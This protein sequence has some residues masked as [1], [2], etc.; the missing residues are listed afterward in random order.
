MATKA[1]A[2]EPEPPAEETTEEQ[3][4]DEN[5]LVEQRQQD[6]GPEPVVRDPDSWDEPSWEKGMFPGDPN[7]Y[8][9]PENTPHGI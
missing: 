8:P 5:P 7:V 4:E 1:S 9:D 2:P 3:P 6:P